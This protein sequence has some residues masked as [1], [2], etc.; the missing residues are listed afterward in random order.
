MQTL[1]SVDQIANLEP[2]DVVERL[3]YVPAALRLIRKELGLNTALLG[4]AG[5]PWTLANYM[6][7]GSAKEF[8]RAKSLFYT[9][10]T[11]FNTLM[12]RISH[13]VTAFLQ[14][15]INAGV[16]AVQI[17]DS[18]GGQL[19]DNAFF[20]GSGRWMQ[21]IIANLKG[22]VPVIVFSKSTHGNWDDLVRTHANVL[23]L[24][25]TVN[26]AET[27]ALLP[28]NVAV[29]G[30]LDPFVLNTTPAIVEREVLRL[31]I[32]MKNTPGFIFNL[33]HGV[34]PSAK[35]EN[36]ESLTTTVQNFA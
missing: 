26:L 25:W 24:D 33:G 8:S 32:D 7:E 31:L 27:A 9:D 21:Q 28:R 20:E 23:G 5:S 4:F 36:I 16:D 18:C 11:L 19:A 13:A 14:M 15:Q 3:Q 1:T 35:L 29:Q 34:P 30:N 10:R 22:K 6:L 2:G 17:F 12:E